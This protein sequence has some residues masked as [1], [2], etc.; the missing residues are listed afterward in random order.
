MSRGAV[1]LISVA[2]LDPDRQTMSEQEWN[3]TAYFDIKTL[4]D[5]LQIKVSTLYAWSA[6]SKIPS[7][8]IHG[9]IRFR[10]DEIDA[11][12]ED[13][14]K[15]EPQSQTITFNDKKC[16]VDSLI[17]RAKREVYN[18]ACGETRPESAQRKEKKDGAV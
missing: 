18:D 5:Y 4:S 13:F 10:K 17:A 8:K 7:I 2:C 16:D 1:T 11:W 14:R 6:Q 15:R 9:V 12:L 3:K